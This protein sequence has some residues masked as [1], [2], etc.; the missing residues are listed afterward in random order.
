M[1]Y[2][3]KRN[4]SSGTYNCFYLQCLAYNNFLKKKGYDV[5]FLE[6]KEILDFDFKQDD[7]LIIDIIV[8]YYFKEFLKLKCKRICIS[9]EP[10]FYRSPNY[11][12]TQILKNSAYV[13]DYA[14]ENV[15]FLK[16]HNYH[17][18]MYIPPAYTE[19]FEEIYNKYEP[20]NTD[21]TI[22]VLFYGKTIAYRTDVIEKLKKTKFNVVIKSNLNFE[23]QIKLIKKSKIV[24]QIASDRRLQFFDMYR[25]SFLISNKVLFVHELIAKNIKNI[26]NNIINIPRD[27]YINKIT[28]LLSMTQKQRDEIALK[29]YEYYKENWKMSDFLCDIKI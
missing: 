10:L 7:Y 29:Q 2:Q 3:Y 28:E 5:K 27:E 13:L 18:V 20:E 4:L 12:I 17:N 6:H 23:E 21:K 9:S 26:K 24:L 11:H 19:I 22:D 16:K 25:C 8:L 14:M 15:K 1:I